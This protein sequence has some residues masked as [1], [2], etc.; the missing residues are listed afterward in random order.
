MGSGGCRIGRE[1]HRT[2]GEIRRKSSQ[3]LA[4]HCAL[5]HHGRTE[6]GC[7]EITEPQHPAGEDVGDDLAPAID[8]RSTLGKTYFDNFAALRLQC[9]DALTH[10]EGHALHHRLDKIGRR[11]GRRESCKG[12]KETPF[13]LGVLPSASAVIS[14]EVI[15]LFPDKNVLCNQDRLRPPLMTSASQMDCVVSACGTRQRPCCGESDALASCDK[16]TWPA[17]P[18]VMPR[19]PSEETPQPTASA[20][21]SPAPG[22]TGVL[23]RPVE[24][25]DRASRVAAQF[26]SELKRRGYAVGNF[27]PAL[28]RST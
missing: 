11:C 22:T 12:T 21:I 8:T 25:D 18:S 27:G 20:V 13:A 16:T 3:C 5:G 15:A 23:H 26:G 14:A 1:G 2:A 28:P 9:L 4:G 24:P 17:V 19:I 6:T 7:I 10:V